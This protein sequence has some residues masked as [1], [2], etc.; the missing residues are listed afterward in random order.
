MAISTEKYQFETGPPGQA[1]SAAVEALDFIA[2]LEIPELETS[3][4]PDEVFSNLDL[5]EVFAAIVENHGAVTY[6]GGGYQQLRGSDGKERFLA[7][8]F[9]GKGSGEEAVPAAFH[10]FIDSVGSFT[11]PSYTIPITIPLGSGSPI[12]TRNERGEFGRLTLGERF[13]P[14]KAMDEVRHLA[15]LMSRSLQ[16][17][18]VAAGAFEVI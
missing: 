14:P 4:Q 10:V 5:G 7:T 16:G 18:Q 9:P 3:S 15:S 6:G 11:E 17:Y 13:D 12:V 2:D 8:Y 1:T